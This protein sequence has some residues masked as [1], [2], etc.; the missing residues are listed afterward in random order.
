M[1]TMPE[2]L[3][4]I[5]QD[6]AIARIQ[7]ALAGSR[8]PHALLFAGPAG[9]G[10]RTTAVALAKTLLCEAPA[11]LP[12][13]GRLPALDAKAKLHQACGQCQ[14]CR[15]VLADSHPDFYRV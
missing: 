9:V 7:R 13:D 6:E 15:M 3:D 10:R 2:L 1:N 11:E 4:I 12:N 8:M 5:G 14:D